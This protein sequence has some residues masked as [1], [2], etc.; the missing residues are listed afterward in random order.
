[1]YIAD[2]QHNETCNAAFLRLFGGL[3][4]TV[5][6][7]GCQNLH[8][9]SPISADD[10]GVPVPS[11][12]VTV[13]LDPGEKA[14]SEL[15]TGKAIEIGL[16]GAK[17][18]GDQNHTDQQ[19]PVVL[20]NIQFIAP[21]QLRN[22]FDFNYAHISLRGRKFFSE[23]A[24]GVEYSGGI[25]RSSLGLAVSSATQ[26]ASAHFNNYGVQAGLGLIWRIQPRTSLQARRS[27]FQSDFPLLDIFNTSEERGVSGFFRNELFITQGIG[28]N[29][30]LRAGYAEW[31]VNGTSGAGMSDFRITFSGPVFDIGLNF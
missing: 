10:R 9:T 23:R 6:L 14:S 17:G 29:L 31:E 16:M 22:D 2:C 15:Q 5:A 24:L 4:S 25:G 8:P 1:M 27:M 19:L 7:A 18:K 26:H 3:L 21:Q 30:S 20:N 11:V 13:S 12:S 28:D